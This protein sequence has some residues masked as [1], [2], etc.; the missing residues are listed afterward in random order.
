VP[1]DDTGV[2]RRSLL[3]LG[4][5]SRV[6]ERVDYDAVTERVED[7]WD[8]DGHEPLLRAIEPVAA[9]LVELAGVERDTRVLDAAAG[10]GNVAAAAVALGADVQAC[11]LARAMVTR[12]RARV[13]RAG[14]LRADV[15]ELPYPAAMFDAVIS[16]F[17]AV[18]APRARRTARELVR[19]TR[20]GGIVVL[21]AWVPD[22]LPGSLD[23]R[24]DRPEGMRSPAEWGIEELA[25]RRLA[26]HL[27]ALKF[28]ARTVRLA[29]ADADE[30][31]TAFLRPL[32]LVGAEELGGVGAEIDARYLVITGRRP[33]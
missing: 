7:A 19:V 29:F 27:E 11:D 21:T 22:G 32:G 17:G 10:D 33:A 12:G 18:L 8:E 24:V 23:A 30:L 13:P 14:W 6:R 15:Q 28:E 25:R 9:S 4:F 3:Q 20:P 31:A 5:L 2:S 26:P 16:N 1:P